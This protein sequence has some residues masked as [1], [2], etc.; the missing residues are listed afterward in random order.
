M[1]GSFAC[2][3]CGKILEVQGRAPGR[4][5]RCDFCG[6]LLEV[7]YLVRNAPANWKR[8][9]LTRPA[10]FVWTCAGLGTVLALLVILVATRFLGGR[11]DSLNSRS[12]ERLLKS[13]RDHENDRRLDLALVDL[14]AAIDLATQVGMATKPA[15][16]A[17]RESRRDL[18]TRDVQD[19]LSALSG[20]TG[21]IFPIGRWLELRARCKR[22]HDLRS[23]VEPVETAFQT[24]L[25]RF[26]DRSLAT[27][28]REANEGA[29]RAALDRCDE[30]A[31]LIEH[32]APLEREA[33]R[34]SASRLVGQLVA[35][36]G[37]VVLTPRGTF[38]LGS[39][40]SYEREM[41]PMVARTLEAKG[42][43][44]YRPQSSF[45]DLW[46]RAA[47]QLRLVVTE[48]LEGNYLSSQNRL[49]R[50]EV[51]LDLEFAADRTRIWRT[52]PTARTQVPLP[53]LPAL[54]SSRAA[55]N[56]ER[57]EEIERMLYADARGRIDE[58]VSFAL[59]NLPPR[60][61]I[62]T[63]PGR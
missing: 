12:V 47:Y 59:S 33:R 31:S 18:A 43:L 21:P 19:V 6:R 34:A 51:D 3:E 1:E 15:I 28:Q 8:K 45:R 41:L 9:R 39:Q 35:S 37:V 61:V 26:L 20:S 17:A 50:I 7:P 52:M 44:P 22:D 42:Y 60:G 58:K 14:D 4:Q 10:W 49:S 46:R 40:T 2:P 29:A 38:V 53:N 16:Q 63:G 23:L 48:S 57:S 36:Q 54:L 27:A 62:S 55:A 11:R 13:S 5:I 30:I 56:P 25:P 24:W 32:L